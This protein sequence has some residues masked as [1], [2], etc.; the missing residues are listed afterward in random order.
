MERENFSYLIFV[1]G[2]PFFAL[3]DVWNSYETMQAT[4]YGI[5]IG[6][7]KFKKTASVYVYKKNGEGW[8]RFSS[9]NAR[10]NDECKPYY[11]GDEMREFAQKLS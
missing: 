11:T 8:Q 5:W 7:R 4:K 9:F 3:V 10:S 6:V 2:R 1:G